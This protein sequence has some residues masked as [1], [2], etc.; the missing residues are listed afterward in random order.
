MR[1]KCFFVLAFCNVVSCTQTVARHAKENY[2]N[3]IYNICAMAAAAGSSSLP[4]LHRVN[5]ETEVKIIINL[6]ETVFIVFES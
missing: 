4:R 2:M 1:A 5:A 6:W 3:W